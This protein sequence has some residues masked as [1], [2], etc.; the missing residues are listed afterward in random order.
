MRFAFADLAKRRGGEAVAV[1]LVAG[2]IFGAAGDAPAV[3]AIGG[4]GGQQR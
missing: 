1:A 2:A 4:A 3:V